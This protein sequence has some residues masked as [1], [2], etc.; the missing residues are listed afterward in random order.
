MSEFEIK[1]FQLKLF[2]NYA[3][4][5]S[6]VQTRTHQCQLAQIFNASLHANSHKIS[7]N[8]HSPVQTRTHQCQFAQIFNA[9][10]HSKYLMD[11]FWKFALILH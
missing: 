4:L 5:H 3:T 8:L 9:S 2:Q 11:D 6:P 1:L 7:A 10:W